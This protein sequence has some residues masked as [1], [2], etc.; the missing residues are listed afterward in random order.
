MLFKALVRVCNTECTVQ[1]SV[2]I[3]SIPP[4]QMQLLIQTRTGQQTQIFRKSYKQTEEQ[5]KCA[6]TT[7]YTFTLHCV[8]S[9]VL[10]FFLHDSAGNVCAIPVQ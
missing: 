3:N 1:E 5:L 4:A 2:E 7:P 6:A 10:K 8:N 9:I